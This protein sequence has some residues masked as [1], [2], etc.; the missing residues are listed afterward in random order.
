[1]GKS[2]TQFDLPPIHKDWFDEDLISMTDLRDEES[3]T[4][5]EH[6]VLASTKLNEEQK[7]SYDIIM[8]RIE[9]NKALSIPSSPSSKIGN[10]ISSHPFSSSSSSLC[11]S[12]SNFHRI[13]ED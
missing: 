4:I 5:D 10:S 13:A 12:F 6:D 9:S 7:V 11:L 1:M 2:T 3:I 8:E